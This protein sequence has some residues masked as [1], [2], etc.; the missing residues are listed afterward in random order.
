MSYGTAFSGTGSF[1]KEERARGRRLHV[2]SYLPRILFAASEVVFQG[3]LDLPRGAG[4]S[5]DAP[6]RC[7]VDVGCGRVEAGCV[8]Q[9]EELGANLEI[10]VFRD[11]ELFEHGEIDAFE[12]ILAQD[13][14]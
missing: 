8:C 14:A 5:S 11:P 4:R 10:A 12:I 9:V 6:A 1:R 7:H 2:E 3:E 13:I